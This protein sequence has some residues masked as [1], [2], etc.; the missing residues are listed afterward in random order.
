[1]LRLSTAFPGTFTALWLIAFTPKFALAKRVH[2]QWTPGKKWY[3]NESE[4]TKEKLFEDLGC[5]C[6]KEGQALLP[7]GTQPMVPR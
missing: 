7:A 6:K 2:E 1:M 3:V 5:Y 4:V